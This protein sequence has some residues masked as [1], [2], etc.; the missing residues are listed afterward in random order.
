[1]PPEKPKLLHHLLV[2][3]KQ[4]SESEYVHPEWS[5]RR[6][7]IGTLSFLVLLKQRTFSTPL[8]ISWL[9]PAIAEPNLSEQYRWMADK[10]S[11]CWLFCI[12]QP[13]WCRCNSA[14]PTSPPQCAWRHDIPMRWFMCSRD[15]PS[16]IP[17]RFGGYVAL[18]Q[19]RCMAEVHSG[20]RLLVL[21]SQLPT[22]SLN[23]ISGTVVSR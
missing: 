10:Q 3:A 21:V 7:F 15:T 17:A 8:P 14:I 2:A 18:L 4:W 6:M 23:T 1:M 22:S 12:V 13:W 16:F 9:I 19:K 20:V 11:R 5:C